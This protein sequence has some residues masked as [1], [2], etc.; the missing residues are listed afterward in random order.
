MV[1]QVQS[2]GNELA[3]LSEAEQTL[4]IA[5]G[6]DVSE[7]LASPDLMAQ[8]AQF[9]APLQ[10]GNLSAVF[11]LQEAAGPPLKRLFKS[12]GDVSRAMKQQQWPNAEAQA[13]LSVRA[14]SD[15][16]LVLTMHGAAAADPPSN[17]QK[18]YRALMLGCMSDARPSLLIDGAA[19]STKEKTLLFLDSMPAGQQD[20]ALLWAI[21]LMMSVLQCC[22]PE[23]A[24]TTSRWFLALADFVRKQRTLGATWAA[25][26]DWWRDLMKRADARV[27]AFLLHMAAD[28]GQLDP[29]WITDPT[30]SYSAAYAVARAPEI[31]L[32]AVQQMN[33]QQGGG[34]SAASK[35]M[36]SQ[37]DRMLKARGLGKGSPR[38]PS[39]G[40]GKHE[41]K[42]KTG[43]KR[44]RD[45]KALTN[46]A[47]QLL[48]TNK[49]GIKAS[50]TTS[51]K[52]PADKQVYLN[53][54]VFK[55][56]FPETC[57][58]LAQEMG[59]FNNMDPCPFFFLSSK[60]CRDGDKCAMYH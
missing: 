51:G 20:A 10:A 17:R 58:K 15:R 19:S 49:S 31:A 34:A 3:G 11:K 38:K 32:S 37:L 40:K 16:R 21:M 7:V 4:S 5:L 24:A 22:R 27:D 54:G 55:E 39:P 25:L 26:S 28:V 47:G 6:R 52:S 53:K 44:D 12:I 23:R 33:E 14:A 42:E 50:G 35:G 1:V 2:N 29:A 56:P 46:P 9:E 57:R 13:V 30:A 18:G 8:L 41:P 36:E 59:Q 48:L 45:G 60:P 43:N